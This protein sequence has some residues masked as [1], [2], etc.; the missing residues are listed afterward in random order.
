MP[1]ALE[2]VEHGSGMNQSHFRLFILLLIFCGHA[3]TDAAKLT[4]TLTLWAGAAPGE[5]GDIK[6]EGLL[7]SRP[8]SKVDR[9]ANVSKPTITLYPAPR[10]N[11]TGA[12]VVVCPG[13]GYNILAM[14]LEGTEVCEWLNSLGVNAVLLKYRVPRRKGRPKH[15]APLQDVQRTFGLVRQN[16]A[17]W[18]IDPS[19][20]GVL[21]FSAGGHLSATASTNH[22]KRIY[23]RVD[24]ADDLSCRPDFTIL[25][26]PAYLV[27]NETKTK[28]EPE[29]VINKNTPP[30]FLVHAGNDRIPAE[31]SVQYYLALRRVGV[32]AELHIHPLGG[33]GFGLRTS[34]FPI[35][36]WPRRCGEWMRSMRFLKK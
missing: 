9:L 30:A 16:A 29:F 12:A 32:K 5:R 36:M 11:N 34:D 18:D 33:H 31:G 24:A 21:G 4:P 35:H 15:E 2:N 25:V 8:G 10:D 23:E 3:P 13:G 19:R 14:D 28:L 22:A 26:Y 6:K 17:D 1:R 20:I 27:D 7:P